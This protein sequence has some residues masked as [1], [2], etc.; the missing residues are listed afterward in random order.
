MAA[1]GAARSFAERLGQAQIAQ[2]LEKTLQEEK[3][4][5]QKLT[6]ISQAINSRATRAA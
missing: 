3:T 4:A 2:T 6:Q 5:D 1:Y